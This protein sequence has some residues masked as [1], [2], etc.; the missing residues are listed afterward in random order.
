[1]N[2][3]RT[4]AVDIGAESGR[5]MTADFDGDR[6]SLEEAARFSNVPLQV[7]GSLQWDAKR[8][9]ADV[10][11]GLRA[12][13]QFQSVGIDTWGVDFGLLDRAG[14]LLGNPGHYRDDRTRGMIEKATARVSRAEIYRRTGVQFLEINTLYQLLALVLAADARLH[15]AHRLL[16]MPALVGRWLTAESV[17]EYTD[18]TTTQCFDPTAGEWAQDLLEQL[19]IPTRI[20]GPVVQ[21][22]TVLGPIR[23]EL[24]FGAAVVIAPGTHDTASAVAAVPFRPGAN[25]AYISS[26]TWSLVGLELPAPLINDATLEANLT[27]EGG[28]AG[29]TR[30]LKNVMGLWLVQ[31]CRR[32]W[33]GAGFDHTYDDLLALAA[34]APPFAAVIDPDDG[35][36]LR[37]GNMPMQL[38]ELAAESHQALAADPGAIVR[39]VLESLTL[40]YRWT[41]ERLE[42]VTGRQISL[43]HVVGGGARNAL[44]CQMTADASRR[45]V[46]AGPMEAT[47][48][49]N[50][51]LQLMAL[52][53]V[54]SLDQARELVRRS[55]DLTTYE[56]RSTEVWEP[57]W[58]RF[59]AAQMT[60]AERRTA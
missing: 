53:M 1:M 49:G 34:K 57:A 37:P 51:I 30:L 20:F 56:P 60:A 50:V 52:G 24:Q 11:A 18:A 41:I 7:A 9:R 14:N 19:G 48:I 59:S 31:E 47:A 28:V 3:A 54:D 55:I 38:I 44:L 33:A 58:E 10:I 17:D 39:C 43:I 35:R 6:L 26:G 15:E 32:A 27:N 25:A 21:P 8:L 29:T 2:S 16:T 42:S 22:G 12:A 13:G 36:L 23:E 46:L 45:S 5:V 4:V 40:K